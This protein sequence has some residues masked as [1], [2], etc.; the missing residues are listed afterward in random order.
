MS[1]ASSLEELLPSVNRA[2]DF[3]LRR[4][5]TNGDFADEF[6]GWVFVKMLERDGARLKRFRGESAL[7]TYLRVVVDRLYCDY[8]ISLNGK[9]H[10]SKKAVKLGSRV[11]ELE[12]LVYY[13]GFTLDQAVSLMQAH[14]G[15]VSDS[16][17][18]AR[19]AEI[20]I[21]HRRC[22]VSLESVP[23]L[24]ADS[25][26]S[27]DAILWQKEIEEQGSRVCDSLASA[28]AQL[29]EEDRFILEL[30]FTQGLQVSWISRLVGLRPRALYGRLRRI[31]RLLKKQ[32][33]VR[34]VDRGG[35]ASSMHGVF[36]SNEISNV[37][38]ARGLASLARN[39]AA[40]STVGEAR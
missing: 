23:E 21:R 6:R 3:V 20:P 16:D 26:S 22:F 29:P 32:L 14:H 8:L 37:Q 4:R 9:W 33:E 2:V 39:G 10:P 7:L 1:T 24:S 34:G 12:R 25:R 15:G 28:L 5:R 19:F 38:M 13:D 35:V 27:A 11:V 30:R 40:R 17:L 18:R 31:L 36:P